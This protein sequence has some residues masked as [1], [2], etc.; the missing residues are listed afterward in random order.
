MVKV[1]HASQFSPPLRHGWRSSVA[2]SIGLDGGEYLYGINTA[3]K[4]VILRGADGQVQWESSG[5]YADGRL[6]R[7]GSRLFAYR[8]SQGLMYLDHAGDT[9][10]ETLATSFGATP[11]AHMST[12]VIDGDMVVFAVN[13]GLYAVSQ[14]GGLQ[15][16]TL[17]DGSVPHSVGL[18]SPGQCFLINGFG[19]PTLYHLGPK[20][21]ENVW[22]GE[23]HGLDAGQRVRPFAV[24][25]NHLVISVGQVLLGYDLNTGRIAWRTPGVAATA[26][27]AHNGVVYCASF[28]CEVWAVV[29]STG[30]ILWT[31]QYIYDSGL[32]L[33]HGLSVFGDHLY[34]GAAL[35]TN[36]DRAI[37]LAMGLEDGSFEWLSRSAAGAWSGG[38]PV[39]G[40][41]GRLYVFSSAHSGMYHLSDGSPS[42][43]TDQLTVTPRPITGA[44][45][46]FP[47][48]RFTINLPIAAQVTARAY[49]ERQGPG[50]FIV[51]GA[52]WAAG[53]HEVE[54]TVGGS[55]GFTDQNQFG[56]VL[57][58]VT[59]ASGVPYSLSLLLPVNTFPDI[60]RHWA[61][62]YINTMV[63]HQFAN[64]YPDQTFRP[65]N[66]VLRAESSTIIAKTLGLNGPTPGFETRFTDLA[67]H[68]ARP[69]ILALEERGVVGGF[70]E[71]DGSYTFRPNLNMTRG[72]EARI[73]VQ[74]YGIAD[75]PTGFTTRFRDIA[76]HWA[77]GDIKA[78]ESAGY[79]SG[80]SEPDGSFTYR[81]E[82]NLTRAELCAL[83]V[84]IRNLS[85]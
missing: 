50:I 68:W 72:Q 4:A 41:N 81:P 58:D 17:L 27:A 60:Q 46:R 49:R 69:Y 48:G 66:L 34:F 9:V 5:T 55:N 18:R 52:R 38:I 23:P 53:D 54:W 85:R 42:V 62:D 26:L 75:A 56:Y 22:E 1:L 16:G 51:N 2:L 76:G 21:F 57:I 24:A 79:I 35:Q 77:E 25:A 15:Y 12:P 3:G 71:P 78:L 84:R 80:Y 30:Q 70:L 39:G 33:E 28:G 40:E 44:A 36:P 61:R 19:V 32:H 64:G 63:Y 83:I 82:Q 14:Q 29:A 6:A 31:R 43:S 73:L 8:L 67:G 65:D 11:S 7:Q 47:R 10:T 45:S 59:E 20:S 13:Q 37:L 74:A